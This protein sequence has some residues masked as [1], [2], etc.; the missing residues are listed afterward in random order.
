MDK[1]EKPSVLIEIIQE[2]SDDLDMDNIQKIKTITFEDC[3]FI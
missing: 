2:E 1:Q 3:Y